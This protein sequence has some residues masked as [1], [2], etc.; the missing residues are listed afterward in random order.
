MARARP[1]RQENHHEFASERSTFQLSLPHRVAPSLTPQC[2]GDMQEVTGTL[3]LSSS[4]LCAVL[5]SRFSL[6]PWKE[7]YI[8][9]HQLNEEGRK[10]NEMCNWDI[11]P[12]S[13][14]QTMSEKR[15]HILKRCT[16]SLCSNQAC[17]WA[18]PTPAQ[19]WFW[20]RNKSQKLRAEDAT[21]RL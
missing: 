14:L 17:R 13:N 1:A 8:W 6:S 11:T 18:I 19:S 12:F 3:W 4:H 21:G 16:C 5:S 15:K 2:G 20:L 7:R 9:T 10:W